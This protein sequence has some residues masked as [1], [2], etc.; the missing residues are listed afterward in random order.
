VI[1]GVNKK[2]WRKEKHQ[3][4]GQFGVKKLTKDNE[5]IEE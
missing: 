5:N 4:F 2:Q 3:Y 1:R